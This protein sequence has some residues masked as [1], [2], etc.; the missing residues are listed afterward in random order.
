MLLTDHALAQRLEAFEAHL[1]TEYATT[2]ARLF[3]A[4]GAA[5]ATIAGGT[6]VFAGAESPLTQA[7]GLGMN[8]AVAEA[9]VDRLEDFY[10]RRGAPVNVEFCPH[11]DDSLRQSFARRGYTL[12]EQLN[13]FVQE[14]PARRELAA[15]A[16][17]V[18]VRQVQP[19]EFDELARVVAQAFMH[20]GEPPAGLIAVFA[21]LCHMPM[22]TPFVAEIDGQMIGGGLAAV[23]D[24]IVSLFATSTLPE[25]RGRG[26][27]SALIEARLACGATM[28]C[29]LATVGAL[30]GST[31][32][33]NLER[34]G[35]RVVYTRAKLFRA[36]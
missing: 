30:P 16:A 15:R 6:A 29:E 2:H 18:T 33:R 27:Q 36:L 26:A 9:E 8:G 14:V 22:T 35:F 10:R 3:P 13:V 4:E 23:R 1:A 7:V 19:N 17:D 24:G 34:H 11:A 31:S 28:N 20:A 25:S 12:I 5:H 32:H 21:V